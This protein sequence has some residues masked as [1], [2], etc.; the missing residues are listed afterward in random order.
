MGEVL[1]AAASCRISGWLLLLSEPSTLTR[2]HL[3]KN[4]KTVFRNSGKRQAMGRMWT[5]LVQSLFL[6]EEECDSWREKWVPG[7]FSA[8]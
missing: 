6:L 2:Q 7:Q 5:K 3:V 1:A 8:H 4:G